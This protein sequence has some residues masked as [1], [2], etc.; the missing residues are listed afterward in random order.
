MVRFLGY[1]VQLSEELEKVDGKLKSTLV[2]LDNKVLVSKAMLIILLF[3]TPTG[4]L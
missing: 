1:H 4:S 3:L 2:L